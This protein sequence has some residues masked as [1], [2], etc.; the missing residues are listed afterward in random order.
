[1]DA[2]YDPSKPNNLEQKIDD[3]ANQNMFED[4]VYDD[5][6]EEDQSE[7]EEKFVERQFNFVQEMSILVD[8]NVIS[9]Y[10]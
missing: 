5:S 7:E 4:E 2:D 9:R 10:M 3:L 1:M 6:E 8:Y